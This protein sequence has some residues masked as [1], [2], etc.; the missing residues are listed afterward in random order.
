MSL[1]LGLWRII[2]GAEKEHERECAER[3]DDVERRLAL[4]EARDA[5]T[6][7]IEALTEGKG[8]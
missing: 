1:L 4:L 5:M 2:S 3:L 8:E 7:A 6:V